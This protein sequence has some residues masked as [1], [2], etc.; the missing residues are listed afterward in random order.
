MK[1]PTINVYHYYQQFR[2]LK[3]PTPYPS[4]SRI[5]WRSF[6]PFEQI[7]NVAVCVARIL[8]RIWFDHKLI[9]DAAL[10]FADSDRFAN[11]RLKARAR[12]GLSALQNETNKCLANPHLSPR[13]IMEPDAITLQKVNWFVSA[14]DGKRRKNSEGESEGSVH[15]I[16]AVSP[17]SWLNLIG[18][19]GAYL[20][21]LDAGQAL[22]FHHCHLYCHWHCRSPLWPL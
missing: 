5:E 11:G 8:N 10:W 1:L 14:L 17:A 21:R 15:T 20:M 6:A 19:R 3:G 9:D 22:R 18:A 2:F 16:L 7:A 4:F 13:L 12:L